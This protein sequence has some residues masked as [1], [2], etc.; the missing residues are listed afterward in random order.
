[1]HRK[2]PVFL[3]VGLAASY[4]SQ[5]AGF[6][7]SFSNETANLEVFSPVSRLTDEGGQLT[8]GLFYNELD[9]VLLHGKLLAV[10]T[11]MHARVPYQLSFG[12]KLYFGQLDDINPDPAVSTDAD[13]GAVAI[14]GAISIQYPSLYNPI[15]LSVEGYFTPGITTFGDTET[16]V[17][18]GARLSIEIVPQAKAFVGYRLLEVDDESNETIELDDNVHFG[19]RL[20]F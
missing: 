11:Q 20:Q 18:I 7:L 6:D 13:V 9:D 14:G 5:A 3:L 2:L 4:Q 17:E 16:L 1:M 12:A 10:G 8:M 19:I 15:D